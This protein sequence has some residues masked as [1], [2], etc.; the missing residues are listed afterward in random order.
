M[1]IVTNTRQNFYW[2]FKQIRNGKVLQYHAKNVCALHY[3]FMGIHFEIIS[4]YLDIIFNFVKYIKF[5]VYLEFKNT[6]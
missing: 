5:R 4:L 3:F 1:V 2:H 6:Y